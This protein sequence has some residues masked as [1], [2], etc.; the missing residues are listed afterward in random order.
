MK[1]I[2][3]TPYNASLNET[4]AKADVNG[5][6]NMQE[7]PKVGMNQPSLS[8]PF[9][10][11]NVVNSDR[12]KNKRIA[13]PCVEQYS[14]NKWSKHRLQKVMMNNGLFFFEFES[15]QGLEDLLENG[16][17]MIR[18]VRIVLKKW[19]PDANLTKED[20]SKVP[21]W[22]K[23]H[24]VP[25]GRGSFARALIE[26][27]ATCGLK[28][29]LVVVIPKL[30]SKAHSKDGKQ[31]DVWDDGFQSVK[32]KTSKDGN[33][34]SQGKRQGSGFTKSNNDSY[35]PVM[36]PKSSTP[37]SNSFS[38]LEE[39]NGNSM[40]DLADD[41]RKKLYY[42]DRDDMEFDDMKQVVEEAKHGNASSENG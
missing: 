8:N 36:K 16:P 10:Y 33:W 7:R 40:D 9:T 30:G 5:S 15:K 24:N 25:M 39:Y 12:V 19:S 22:V 20:L 35:R 37:V 17:Y 27:D 4:S 38:T 21:V 23:L 13:Y 11:A 6:S 31:K 1:S 42:F 26:L 32:R 14:W 29:M 3:K 41:T 28:D 18:N 2:L 34:D